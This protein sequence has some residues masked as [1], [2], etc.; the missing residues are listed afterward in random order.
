MCDIFSHPLMKLL[1]YDFSHATI[2]LMEQFNPI[3]SKGIIGQ[4]IRSV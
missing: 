2:C 1:K 4:Q 3:Q